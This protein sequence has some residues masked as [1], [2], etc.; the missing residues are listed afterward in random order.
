MIVVNGSVK[1]TQD[2][3]I[4]PITVAEGRAMT[5]RRDFQ[6]TDSRKTYTLWLLTHQGTT[7]TPN[8][9]SPSMSSRIN[10]CKAPNATHVGWPKSVRNM[11]VSVL[12][13]GSDTNIRKARMQV[14][15]QCCATNELGVRVHEQLMRTAVTTAQSITLNIIIE[16]L[17]RAALMDEQLPIRLRWE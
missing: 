15:S 12:S 6:K 8:T 17:L 5:P 9:S 11:I 14:K 10:S 2:E 16:R 4:S 13:S 1:A 3:P 7:C